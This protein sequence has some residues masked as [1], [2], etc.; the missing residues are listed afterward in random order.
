[1]YKAYS[2]LRY[3]HYMLPFMSML[4]ELKLCQRQFFKSDLVWPEL[5]GHDASQLVQSSFARAVH[6]K[7]VSGS[8]GQHAGDVDDRPWT[9]TS[10][11]ALG[12]HL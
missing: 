5:K 6:C 11:E 4:K 8:H 2:A 3:K 9:S 12:Y 10:N 1:M 7:F